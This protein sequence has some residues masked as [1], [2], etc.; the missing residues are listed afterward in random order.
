[1]MNAL[2]TEIRK[3]NI[4][5]RDYH[6]EKDFCNKSNSVP[7]FIL[8]IINFIATIIVGF[9]FGKEIYERKN[10]IVTTSETTISLQES[11]F[12]LGELPII[13]NFADKVGY[14]IED[15][16][17]EKIL[18]ITILG[19]TALNGVISETRSLLKKCDQ[20]NYKNLTKLPFIQ[21]ITSTPRTRYCMDTNLEVMN[22]KGNPNSKNLAIMINKCRNNCIPELEEFIEGMY[23]GL[24]Y[25]NDYITPNNY[26]Q[27]I[28]YNMKSEAIKLSGKISKEL[29]FSFTKNILKTNKGW[30][31][32]DYID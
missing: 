6:F 8:T 26:S 28:Q 24:I 13:F 17:I 30:I 14:P 21:Q 22:K 32:E 7:S 18:N 15:S 19:T 27:P 20:N 1:M 4:F 11:I 25:I 3:I 29:T 10:P 16:K 12:N 23:I 2:F 9:I 31:F 5:G